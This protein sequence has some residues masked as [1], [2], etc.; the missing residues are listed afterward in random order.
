MCKIFQKIVFDGREIFWAFHN[1]LHTLN[2]WNFKNCIS[3]SAHW[4]CNLF[5]KIL[6]VE[7]AKDWVFFEKLHTSNV[8][9]FVIFWVI[10]FVECAKIFQKIVFVGCAKFWGFLDKLCTLN[11]QNYVNCMSHCTHHILYPLRLGPPFSNDGKILKLKV[12]LG[13]D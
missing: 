8:H 9:H 5:R 11:V 4:M 10:V 3:H 7:H 1:Q 12:G 6:D 2:V 13:P